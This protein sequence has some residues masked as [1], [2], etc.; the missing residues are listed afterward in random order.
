VSVVSIQSPEGRPIALLGNYSTHY[1]GAPAVSADYFAVFAE[2]F[3][4]LIGADK[5]REDGAP[6]FMGVMSNGTSGDTNCNN[7]LRPK[8]EYDRFTVGRDTAEAAFEAYQRIQ[9]QD[10]VPLAMAERK[11]TLNVRLA[12][13]EEL[14]KAKQVVA[15][16][17]DRK[18][19]TLE[20]IYAREAVILSELPPTRELK[21]Q[22]IRIGDLGIAAIPNE[23]FSSTGL[24]IKKESPFKTTF[25]IELA[26]GAEGYIP[27][28]EQHKLGGYTT[29][30]ART[31]SLEV[32]AEPKIRATIMELLNEVAR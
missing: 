3:G 6:P 24:T 10:W 31:S 2:K 23:V 5:V 25:T 18:P 26:N 27:P 19:K 4:E 29:W 22:A 15:A 20:E 14:A 17:E 21:L 13:A 30:R 11:L 1:A 9:Y 8:R 28:P 32:E 7:F 12:G 16:L